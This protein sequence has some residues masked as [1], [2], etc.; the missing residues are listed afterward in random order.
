MNTTNRPRKLDEIDLRILNLLQEDSI[1][2][3]KKVADE[4]G[5]GIAVGRAYKRARIKSWKR[6]KF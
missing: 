4:L 2:S 5:I 3:Y 1:R 6:R